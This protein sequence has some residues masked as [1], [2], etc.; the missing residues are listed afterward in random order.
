MNVLILQPDLVD[1]RVETYN[2]I[3]K[4]YKLDVGY[5]FKDKTKTPC[6]FNKLFLECKKLGPFFYIK[7]FKQLISRYSVV[8]I[9][10]DLH[11]P[12]YCLL[13]FRGKKPKVIS[14]GIG[15]RVS[16]VHP[17]I[18]D[19]KHTLLDRINQ[20]VLAKCDANIFYMERAKLFWEKTNFNL[21]KVFVAPNTTSVVNID[22]EYCTKKNL[23]FVG[24]LY[25]GKGVDMLISSF[26][27]V[28]KTN[29][30]SINL[31]IVGEGEERDELEQMVRD[32]NISERVI[33]KGAIYDEKELA[34]E[35]KR[36][37]LCI[38]PTQ[39]GLSVPKSMGYGVPF[40]VRKDAI[41]GGEIYHITNNVNGVIY[42]KDSNLFEVIKDALENPQ[43]YKKMGDNAKKYYEECATPYHMAKGAM[44][45][46]AYALNN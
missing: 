5:T 35:F 46:I 15:F 38:S 19:R 29:D 13:P 9:M 3:N 32:L 7:N 21:N 26:A 2:I 39:G 33:F 40:V 28:I 11:Y 45:A 22:K 34:E 12:Q 36:A 16:Y 10:A 18:T 30:F 37:I 6:K 25:K 23:L 24:T 17:Y 14:W 41:T 1:Y 42:E 27:D 44:D 4:H 20:M 43:K 31:V 8:I